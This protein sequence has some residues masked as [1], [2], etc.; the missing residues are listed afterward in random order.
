MRITRNTEMEQNTSSTRSLLHFAW[1]VLVAQLAL[2]AN[3]VIDTAMAGR[4]SAI[5]LASVGIAATIMSTILMSLISVLMALPPI[6]AQLYGAGQRDKIGREI[7]QSIWI[8]LVLALVAILLLHYPEPFIWVSELQPPMEI[9]VRAYLDASV[10]GIPATIALRLFFGLSTGIG[11][12]LPVMTFNLLA[13]CL[14]IPL[15]SVFMFGL[16]GIPAMGAPGCAVATA[17]D[18]WLLASIAWLW[19]LNHPNYREFKILVRFSAPDF[20]AIWEF[21][22][23]GIPIGLTFIA[24]MTAFTFMALFIARLGPIVSGAHQIASNLAVVAFMFP[25]SLGTATAV[26]AGQAIGAGQSEQARHLCWVGIRLGM[27]IAL[28]I[29]LIFWLGAPHIAALYTTDPQVQAAAIPLIILVAFY[30][31]GDAI[32]A[33]AI[34]A[35]RGYKKS[36]VPMVIYTTTLWGVGLGGGYLLG[37]TNTFGQAQGAG[38]FWLAAIISLWLVACLVA[39]YLNT[40]SKAN[41]NKQ[42]LMNYAKILPQK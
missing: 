15:N 33:V 13:L 1:P 4:L 35:L 10:W 20:S 37:L 11:R 32:Q 5:D 3:S 30:H 19:C 8:S 29:S 40:V 38:G 2:M 12:P 25:L 28:I 9:K 18:A 41:L 14:K 24:D 36:A 17:I 31:L 22:R 39:I 23:L 27:I 34:N 6:I 16:L 21:L 7:H 26:L 42:S